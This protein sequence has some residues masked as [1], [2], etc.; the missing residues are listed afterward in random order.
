MAITYTASEEDG[1]LVVKAQGADEDVDQVQEYGLAIIGE[2]TRRGVACVLCD[3][4]DLRY[5]I[6]TLD[7]F[8][9]ATFI[10]EHAPRVARVAL[11]CNP[12]FMEDA[13]FWEN[14]AV[15]RGLIVKVFKEVELAR[16]WLMSL[17][18]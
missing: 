12:K 3:E 2:C 17:K 4:R 8:A 15:N 11:V 16:A 13:V 5:R 18:R 9:V 1:L 14:V 6:N 7:T 10:A